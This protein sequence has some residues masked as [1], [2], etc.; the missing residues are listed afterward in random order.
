[1][2]LIILA[3]VIALIV[4]IIYWYRNRPVLFNQLFITSTD[5]EA[6]QIGEV[7]VFIKKENVARKATVNGSATVATEPYDNVAAENV[8]NGCKAAWF[9]PNRDDAGCENRIFFSDSSK[10]WL[11]LYLDKTYS[12][13]DLDK[14]VIHNR[15]NT[16]KTFSLQVQL[17][18][19][20]NQIVK[21]L[22]GTAQ[23]S[24]NELNGD[25]KH[26]LTL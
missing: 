14:I 1:M 15:S 16:P 22:R 4:G 2:L 8:I 26:I 17:L 19:S 23:S 5:N 20:D 11:R 18:N 21:T 3:L 9:Y 24:N 10:P 25:Q 12:T 7:E 13:G 6:L